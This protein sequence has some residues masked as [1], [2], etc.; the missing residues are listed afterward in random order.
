MNRHYNPDNFSNREPLDDNPVGPSR[1][2][3]QPNF[4]IACDGDQTIALGPEDTEE[5]KL[6][7]KSPLLQRPTSSQKR[8]LKPTDC[9]TSQ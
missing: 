8:P 5:V 7:V 1:Q 3:P 6:W 4:R 9:K 2:A